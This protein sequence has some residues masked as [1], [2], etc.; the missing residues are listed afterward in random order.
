MSE[1]PIVFPRTVGST[2][3]LKLDAANSLQLF[4][5][6]ADVPLYNVSIGKLRFFAN[7][8]QVR[9]QVSA[10]LDAG[11]G[12]MPTPEWKWTFETGFEHSVDGHSNKGWRLTP[13]PT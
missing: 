5:V 11:T 1:T 12:S 7:A 3:V 13:S 10:Y 4:L 6:D 9:Q 8:D 2:T